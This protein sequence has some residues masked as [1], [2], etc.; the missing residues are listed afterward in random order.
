[1]PKSHY[2]FQGKVGKG[3]I[4][5]FYAYGKF[6]VFKKKLVQYMDSL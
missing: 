1:M 4:N 6:K 3:K 5:A 2:I